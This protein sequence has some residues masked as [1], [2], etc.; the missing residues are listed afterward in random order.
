MISKPMVC[1]AQNVH[2][3][4]I[5]TNTASKRTDRFHMTQVTLEFHRVRP[6]RFLSL[7]YVRRKVCTYLASRLAL[8]LNGLNELPLEP[9]HLGVPLGASK[10]IS[11]PMV[12]LM[13]TVHQSCVKM[14]TG[15]KWFTCLWYV[16]R[17]TCTNL[18]SRL[19]HSPN[20]PKRTST[21]ASSTRSTI[22]CIQ[23]WFSSMFGPNHAP[24]LHGH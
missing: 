6:K 15:P 14:R 4:C 24:I 19:A 21:W 20:G 11:K 16:R 2:Q 10:T 3:S 7:W 18:V 17:K 1:S 5:D 22:R 12:H 9:L 23:K 8:S 13:Q